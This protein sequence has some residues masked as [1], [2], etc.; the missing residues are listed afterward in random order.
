MVDLIVTNTKKKIREGVSTSKSFSQADI[1]SKKEPR[2]AWRQLTLTVSHSPNNLRHHTQR[3]MYCLDSNLSEY[4]SGALYDLFVSLG[5]NGRDLRLRLFN[6]ASPVMSI[7]DR[8]YFQQWL[9]EKT[10][11]SLECH[12]FNG[13]V[14]KS[15]SCK[16]PNI[17]KDDKGG[18]S[19]TSPPVF[20]SNLQQ[21]EYMISSGYLAK[22]QTLLEAS[23]LKE[24]SSLAIEKE[25]QRFYF[26]TKKK[27]SMDDFMARLNDSDVKPSKT[28]IDLQEIS[29]SW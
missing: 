12:H 1:A 29:K 3:V 4:V 24:T 16:Q 10:D 5:N 28:W 19:L 21:A 27:K 22:A 6:L 20:E 15:T 18:N 14:L 8:G 2:T 11:K 13:S 26:Y 7:F 9:L 25:L 23:Y 17:K